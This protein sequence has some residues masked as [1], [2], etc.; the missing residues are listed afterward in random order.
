M[1]TLGTLG[2]LGGGIDCVAQFGDLNFGGGVGLGSGPRGPGDTTLAS[3]IL[4]LDGIEIA[5]DSPDLGWVVQRMTIGDPVPRVNVK[6]KS[7]GDGT[8]NR[9]RR[10]ADRNIL[11]Q[12]HLDGTDRQTMLD[13]LAPYM[14]VKNRPTLRLRGERWDT[15]RQVQV[16]YTGDGGATWNRPMV[17]PLTLGF[18]TV[19]SPY[20]TGL[21]LKT[22]TAWP[23]E[24]KPGVTFPISWNLGFPSATGIGPATLINYGTEPAEWTARI[25]GPITG[26][27]LVKASTGETIDFKSTLTVASGDYLTVDSATH[28]VYYNGLSTAS[29]YQY[30]D[31]ANTTTDWFRLDP[32]LNLVRL[33]GD[34]YTVPTQAE[35]TFRDTYLN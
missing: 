7:G 28:T 31:F 10:V 20:F 4:E 8:V 2:T 14:S 13:A 33:S 29:R 18:R 27:R 6:N 25:F 22:S 34:T 11:I 21:E 23:D 32:G 9:T 24:N 26:P 35:I 1:T 30:L 12:L 16:V 3:V 15:H 17:M 5:L 19:G